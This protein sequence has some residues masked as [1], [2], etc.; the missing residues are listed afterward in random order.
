MVSENTKTRPNLGETLAIRRQARAL[1]DR[2]Q[3]ERESSERRLAETGKR[4]P[5]KFITG[6]TAMESAIAAAREM[7]QK[8]DQLLADMTG[9]LEAAGHPM[10]SATAAVTATAVGISSTPRGQQRKPSRLAGRLM[11]KQLAHPAE[12]FAAS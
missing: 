7:V 12:A 8:M 4:D 10:E 1:L 5:M 2:L 9:E 3:T 6:R 11:S